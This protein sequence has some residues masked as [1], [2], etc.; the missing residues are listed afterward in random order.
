MDADQCDYYFSILSFYD[1]LTSICGDGINTELPDLPV[2]AIPLDVY[3][4]NIDIY[5]DL[6]RSWLAE[7][8]EFGI[9]TTSIDLPTSDQL[10]GSKYTGYFHLLNCLIRLLFNMYSDIY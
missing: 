6:R 9:D 4:A 5:L 10:A 7:I 3:D 8:R 2:D 1:G